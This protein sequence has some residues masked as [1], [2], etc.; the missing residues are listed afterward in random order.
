MR[1]RYTSGFVYI[2][3]DKKHKRYYIGSHWGP[4][5]DGYICSSNWMKQAYKIRPQDFKRRIIK[6]IYTSR[7]D[8]LAEENRYLQMIKS[9][10]IKHRYY[11]LSKSN[12]LNHWTGN[13]DKYDKISE[14]MKGNKHGAVPCSPEKAKKISE[15]KK[16]IKFS[17]E[18]IQKLSEAKKGTKHTEERK[19]AARIRMKK[20]WETGARKGKPRINKPHAL[21]LKLKR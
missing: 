3:R 1:E 5:D 15:A 16:G 13:K 12:A 2:W 14:N 8:L 11:N 18:H 20:Q 7:A 19:E 9:E 17:L 4:E 10:E 6:R 21:E